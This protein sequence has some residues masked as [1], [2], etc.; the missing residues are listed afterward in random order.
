MTK[1]KPR[2]VDIT[3]EVRDA[4]YKRV[5]RPAE[6]PSMKV[7]VGG[8]YMLALSKQPN[9]INLMVVIGTHEDEYGTYYD[10]VAADTCPLAGTYDLR[11]DGKGKYPFKYLRLCFL[12]DM[13]ME[14]LHFKD[15]L[16]PIVN[17]DGAP[18]VLESDDLFK[19]QTI[20]TLIRSDEWHG[21]KEQHE[22]DDLPEYKD[23]SGITEAALA[24][25][26]EHCDKID[27][28]SISDMD[29]LNA[30]IQHII[31]KATGELVIDKA[32]SLEKKDKTIS[33]TMPDKSMKDANWGY[34]SIVTEHPAYTVHG[35][36]SFIKEH[37]PDTFSAM[38]LGTIVLVMGGQFVRKRTKEE[39]EV[40]FNNDC[41]EDM[42][43]LKAAGEANILPPQILLL[44]WEENNLYLAM[45]WDEDQRLT[46]ISLRGTAAILVRRKKPIL[47]IHFSNGEMMTFVFDNDKHQ[48]WYLPYNS[49][50]IVRINF[51]IPK[52]NEE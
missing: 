30:D 7:L 47:E 4:I 51:V 16:K 34:Q 38:I 8:V 11:I 42:I 5:S 13:V 33:P 50:S 40:A 25:M 31:E 1:I 41:W 3:T 48:S 23:Q 21:T 45:D 32:P 24:V 12:C 29:G 49:S 27:A 39:W 52:T 17:D 36:M 26:D 15:A 46:K 10:V 6:D 19:A 20:Y 28:L 9:D 44:Q 22:I 35:S 43:Q 18:V 37:F 2:T 14:P